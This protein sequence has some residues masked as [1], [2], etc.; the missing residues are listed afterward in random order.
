[1]EVPGATECTFCPEHVSSTI[2]STDCSICAAGYY[3]ETICTWIAGIQVRWIFA[4][5]PFADSVADR[6]DYFAYA[7]DVLLLPVS[8]TGSVDTI[9]YY[10][11]SD[12]RSHSTHSR[13]T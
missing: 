2:G 8:V 1:M 9:E 4:G 7:Q 5:S 3:N 11:R 13:R 10:A 6:G 12:F